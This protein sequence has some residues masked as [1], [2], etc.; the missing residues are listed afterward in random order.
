MAAYTDFDLSL[1]GNVLTITTERL[2]ANRQYT[3]TIDSTVSGVL[4]DGTYDELD[5][6]YTFWFTSAYCPIFTTVGR[7][8]IEAGPA[9]D[10]LIDDAIYRMI[11]KNS[12][13]II[14][15][16][17]QVN[18]TSIDYDYWGCCWQEAPYLIRRYVECKTAYDILALIDTIGNTNLDQ[19]KTLGDMTIRYGPGSGGCCPSDPSKKKQL[20]DCWSEALSGLNGIKSAVRGYFDHSKGYLH[21]VREM[22][23]NRVIR[24]VSFNN[25][26]PAG[27]WV[28]GFDWR[29]YRSTSGRCC[30]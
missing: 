12:L 9:A 28:C 25:A 4:P 26:D 19:L 30:F 7:V 15:I 29:G 8:K 3:V 17:N 6:D 11:H 2:T 5:S 21:P 10:Y 16:F 23:H 13:D 24:P 22:N 1:D 14:D 20:Y 27:P 18:S